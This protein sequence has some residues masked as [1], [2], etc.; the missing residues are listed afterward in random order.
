MGMHSLIKNDA[1][2]CNADRSV[3]VLFYIDDLYYVGVGRVINDSIFALSKHIDFEEGDSLLYL[4]MRIIRHDDGS[5]TIDQNAH[6]NYM[7]KGMVLKSAAMP[8]A[9]YVIKSAVKYDG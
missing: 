2:Y 3:I 6:I 4:G 7:L 1:V 5:I 8:V 9:P